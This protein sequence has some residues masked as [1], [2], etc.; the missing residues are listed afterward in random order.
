MFRENEMTFTRGDD[1]YLLSLQIVPGE[2]DGF[3]WEI[4]VTENRGGR[5]V[6]CKELSASSFDTTAEAEADGKAQ[7]LKMFNRHPP[8]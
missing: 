1:E 7:L 5:I 3:A 2:D 8:N 6:Q 4:V